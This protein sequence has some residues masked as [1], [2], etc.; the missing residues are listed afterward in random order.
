[1]GN[2]G[3]TQ[4]TP[5]E[6]KHGSRI[7]DERTGRTGMISINDETPFSP[8]VHR[9][10]IHPRGGRTRLLVESEKHQTLLGQGTNQYPK[11]GQLSSDRL[12]VTPVLTRVI[13]NPGSKPDSGLTSDR[14]K[15]K[16]AIRVMGY[17]RGENIP[18]AGKSSNCIVAYK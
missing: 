8:G 2:S 9:A 1:M 16:T 4:S 10:N 5:H 11:Y 13:R 3:G 15:I 6:S 12:G 18:K 14:R 7:L 17:D